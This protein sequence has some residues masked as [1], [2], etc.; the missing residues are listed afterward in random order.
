TTT[1]PPPGAR[2]VP[3]DDFYTETAEAGLDYGPAF[4]GLTALWQTDG[5]LHAQVALPSDPEGDAT[6][7][8]GADG[9]ALHPALLDAALQPLALGVL[10]AD[11]PGSAAVPAGLPFAW[12]GVRL[13]AAGATE[14]Q[15]TLTPTDDGGVRVRAATPD[16]LPVLDIA[17]LTLRAPAPIRAAA[18]AEQPP[19]EPLYRLRWPTVPLS[20][21][22]APTTGGWGMLGLDPRELRPRLAATLGADVVPYL[23]RGALTETIDAGGPAPAAVVVFCD[24]PGHD[25]AGADAHTT[26]RQALDVLRPWLADERMADTRLVLVT[27]GAVTT[28]PDDPGP[29]PGYAAVWGLARTAQTE[30][31]DRV[32]LVDLDD[33]DSSLAALPRALATGEPQ[34]ALRHGTAHVPRLMPLPPSDPPTE[35]PNA[36]SAEPPA[37]P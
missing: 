29:A 34:L 18:R 6:G 5:A 10:G 19:T 20:T 33:T 14:L 12:S 16:G 8:A 15:V 21:T 22:P 36:P 31:P 13:H 32:V 2:R 17:A 30:H 3:L 37:E 35:P 26:T 11:R 7:G 24:P 23:D 27:H 28:G 9:H 4:Q 1:W 25:D